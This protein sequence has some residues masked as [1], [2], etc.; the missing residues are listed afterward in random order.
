MQVQ[1]RGGLLTMLEIP[2]AVRVA[3]GVVSPNPNS[4][5]ETS[6]RKGSDLRL[7]VAG[8]QRIWMTFHQPDFSN[9]L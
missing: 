8:P 7:R 4:D 2:C 9:S 6:F 1:K 3:R 5:R